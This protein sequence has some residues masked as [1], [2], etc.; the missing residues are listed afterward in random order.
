MDT[1]YN[2]N[3]KQIEIEIKRHGCYCKKQET[4]K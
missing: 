4:T 3:N 2:N 1:N